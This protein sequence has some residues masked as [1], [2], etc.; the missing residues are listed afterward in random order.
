MVKLPEAKRGFL[1]LPRRWVVERAYAWMARFR[2]QARDYER[3]PAT[4]AGLHLVAFNV[5]LLRRAADFAVVRNSLYHYLGT[6]RIVGRFD[7]AVTLRETSMVGRP[8]EQDLDAW[9]A[10]F[11]AAMG[12]NTRRIWAPLY[13]RGLLDPGDRKSLQ[14]MAARLGLPGHDQLQHF[15]AS[16]AWDDGPLWAEL[17]RTADRLVG[18]SDA[19]LVID[20]TALPKKGIRSVGV[21]R[22]YCGALGKKA[23][24]QSLVSLTLA[25]DEVPL[26]VGLR[27]F[28]PEDW[29]ADPARCALAGVP[30]AATAPQSKG[31]IALSELDRLQPMGVRFGVVLADAGYG[32]SAAF[33]HGLDARGL[34]WAVGIAKNQKVYDPEVRLVPPG[35]RARK[36]VPDQEP[37]KAEAVLAALPW[38]RVTWRRGTKGALSARFAMARVRVGDGP[39]WANNRHLPGDEVWLVGE[40]RASGERKFYLSNLP[41]RTTRRVLGGTIKA[42]WIREQAHQQIKEELKLD[43]FEGRSWTGLHRHALMTCIAYA[44]LQDLRLAEPYRTD[45]GKKGRQP[46]GAAAVSEPARRASGH[47]RPTVRGAHPARAMPALPAPLP[48]AV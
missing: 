13:L 26:P 22:Q 7:P 24:C 10:P 12:R 14:P 15:I 33:R 30:E 39:V 16:L 27:L 36:A 46:T 32:C 25:R 20:D 43:H 8:S 21:A 28:L 23:S 9:L 48:A 35:G 4:L 31:E 40:W 29:T 2:R 47:H 11:L 17:A 5:L 1:L 37:Q 42:R 19:C 6:L 38:R 45:R 34:T 41:S 44:Y 18:G 3:L